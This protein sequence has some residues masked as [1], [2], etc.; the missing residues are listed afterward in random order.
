MNWEVFWE[1]RGRQ[2]V[3]A[4][5]SS[6]HFGSFRHILVLH[7]HV[8]HITDPMLTQLLATLNQRYT[9]KTHTYRHAKK[10]ILTSA[11][12]FVCVCA[13]LWKERI[14]TVHCRESGKMNA[15]K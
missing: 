2:Q 4:Q 3:A 13:C 6:R 15:R 1:V 14:I 10:R 11:R 12:V 5:T 9:F 8:T 7:L